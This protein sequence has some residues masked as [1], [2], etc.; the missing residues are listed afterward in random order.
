MA[1]L[2]S[3][4]IFGLVC[5]LVIM[6]AV[7][8]YIKQSQGGKVPKL[9]RIPGID[10]I[11]EAIGRAVEMGRPVYCSHGIAD[12][13]AATTGPQTLAGL[14]VLNYVAKRCI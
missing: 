12:L 7:A 13:R 10:A 11:D 5:L 4:R 2:I 1:F 14:S 8:Y 9:R 6:G 3:G